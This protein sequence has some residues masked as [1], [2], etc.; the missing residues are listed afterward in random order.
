MKRP[1]LFIALAFLAGSIDAAEVTAGGDCDVDS[2]ACNLEI[3]SSV[4]MSAGNAL[5]G[6]A[7]ELEE[8]A[9]VR[10]F[11]ELPSLGYERESLAMLRK[12]YPQDSAEAKKRGY[13]ACVG[14]TAANQCATALYIECALYP[15]GKFEQDKQYRASRL[16]IAIPDRIKVTAEDALREV[17]RDI[18]SSLLQDRAAAGARAEKPKP[19][20]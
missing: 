12:R 7:Q 16:S 5:R 17:I 20:K 14:D 18:A 9:R 15:V 19:R 10:L 8:L 6:L 4:E 3:V 1:S 13:L 2:L 11:Y